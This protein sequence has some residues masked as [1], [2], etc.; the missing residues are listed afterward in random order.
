MPS[1]APINPAQHALGGNGTGAR[2]FMHED[3]RFDLCHTHF[4][5]VHTLLKV[6]ECRR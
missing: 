4:E 6:S 1:G 5:V 2:P 3:M